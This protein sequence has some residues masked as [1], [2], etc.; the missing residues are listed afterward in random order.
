M[1]ELSPRRR[2]GKGHLATIHGALG[3]ADSA[4]RLLREA[5]AEGD[6]LVLLKTHPMS[7]PLRSDSR[8]GELLNELGLGE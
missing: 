1:A 3:D 6:V 5:A 8:F 4:F 2:V 7:D